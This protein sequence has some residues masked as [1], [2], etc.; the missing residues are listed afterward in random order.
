MALE[1]VPAVDVGRADRHS[2]VRA[3]ARFGLLVN[4][5]HGREEG[6]GPGERGGPG[7]RGGPGERGGADL[8]GRAWSDRDECVARLFDEHYR[9][10]CRLAGLLLGDSA[11]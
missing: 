3:P 9:G 10:L 1:T 5:G 8:G 7:D 4:D 6:D 2:A 11:A